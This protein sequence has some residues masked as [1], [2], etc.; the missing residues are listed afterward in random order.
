VRQINDFL[1]RRQSF[2]A[3]VPDTSFFPFSVIC[4]MIMTFPDGDYGGTGFYIA[5][6]L[7]LTAG[8]NLLDATGAASSVIIRPG[9]SDSTHYLDSFTVRPSDWT[10]HPSYAAGWN[11]AFDMAV[12]RVNNPP[13]NV[14]F[15]EMINYSPEPEAPIAVCGYGGQ[16]VDSSRQH[17]DIDRV[18]RLTADY[19]MV[20]YNL[21]TRKG[22]SGSPVFAHFTNSSPSGELAMSIPVMGVHV[23][24]SDD[25]H[26]AGVLLTPDKI[27]W[28]RGGGIMSVAQS[29]SGG[30]GQLGGLPLTRRS[31]ATLGGL[32]LRDGNGHARVMATA[33]RY[34]R[35]LER[36][37]IVA[38]TE[39]GMS[40]AR[41]TF[42][43]PSHDLSGKTTLKVSV[44][45]LPA[46][47]RVRWNIP[48]SDDRGRVLFVDGAGATSA[49]ASGMEVSLRSLAAG[50]AYV[51]CM[52]EES[53]GATVESNK[54]VVSSPQFVYVAIDSSVDTFFDGLGLGSRRAAI[55]AEMRP[56]AR[57][58]YEDVNIRLVFPGDTL[59]AH[60]VEAA[61]PA[62]PG[63]VRVSPA[64]FYA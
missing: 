14:E 11:R 32:P 40:H 6:D 49:G 23:K 43:H 38:D 16:D 52:V 33:Q 34:A 3:G 60:L 17:L 15:F 41:R 35:P 54:Y 24:S 1:A 5:H 55:Y 4:K 61:D 18:R 59:P 62:F 45:N 21:Q 26:N 51:D 31:R 48:D 47:G 58:A 7:I 12:I 19:E 53:G 50:V 36:S 37:F 10:V 46:G 27:D 57:A 30:R 9:Q 64:V 29:L 2:V 28:A 44:P 42:G 25:T 8:H 39:R 13:P 20:E 63:G 56:V 22:N